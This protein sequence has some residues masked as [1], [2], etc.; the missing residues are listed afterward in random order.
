MFLLKEL[1][2]HLLDPT[3]TENEVVKRLSTISTCFTTQREELFDYAY[4]AKSVSAYTLFYLPTNALKLKFVLDLLPSSILDEIKQTHIYDI[5][6][7]PGTY[8][9][10]FMKYFS[11][12]VQVVPVDQSPMMRE[13]VQK[14]G[15][16]LFNI[17]RIPTLSSIKDIPRGK[18]STL[19]WGNS[20]NE[21]GFQV[22]VEMAKSAKPQF[23][24]WIEPGTKE[25]FKNYS[26]VRSEIEKAGYEAIFPCASNGKCPLNPEADWCHQVLKTKLTDDV[27]RL[28]QLI[29]K[30]RK[31]MPLMAHVYKK[32]DVA[33][34][35]SSSAEFQVARVIRLKKELKHAFIWQ[36]CL[37]NQNQQLQTLDVE[38]PLKQ[39]SKAKIKELRSIS[40]GFLLEFEVLKELSATL[41]RVKALNI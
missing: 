24:F 3:V 25:V 31:T 23:L 18:D 28:S 26:A 22:A 41:W 36:V 32:K 34:R 20:L 29:K 1:F 39:F 4:E 30:D 6:C 27:E 12:E 7:G 16:G 2:P 8:T 17:E 38:V 37:L 14:L 40:T 19:F 11:N 33:E 15:K 5:G 13:Q 10:A 21:M 35:S 9:W